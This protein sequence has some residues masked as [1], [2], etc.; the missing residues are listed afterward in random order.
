MQAV[1][2]MVAVLREHPT[3]ELEAR[4]GT[5][6][7]RKFVSGV[8]RQ[9]VDDTLNMFTESPY[10]IG[11]S[12]WCEEHDYCYM[13]EGQRLRTRVTFDSDAMRMTMT[14]ISKE[15]IAAQDFANVRLGERCGKLDV[16]V[17]LQSETAVV[18]VPALAKPY[19]VRVKQRRR[20]ACK[21]EG[22]VAWVYDFSMVWS[23]ETKEIAELAQHSC[24]PTFEV[25][26]ELVDKEA[27]L[28]DHT[29][30]HIAQS[31]LMKMTALF[32][33]ESDT[34]VPCS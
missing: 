25:E 29:D 24:E 10:V 31:L 26:C 34:L 15:R 13:H 28:R 21:R 6:K 4:L 23:G 1:A 9:M 14:T 11:D 2:R 18:S 19:H 27:Y 30:D 17:S 8:T 3:Y 20:F 16:R 33:D 12:E 7:D 5:I 22:G 32:E